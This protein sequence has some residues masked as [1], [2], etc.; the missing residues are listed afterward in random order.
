MH[1]SKDIH[2]IKHLQVP[3]LYIILAVSHAARKLHLWKS[4]PRKH[5][6]MEEGQVRTDLDTIVIGAGIIGSWTALHLAKLG[7]KVLVIERV[8]F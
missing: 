5:W 4:L 3:T 1:A 2:A 7:Q 6:K 8:I